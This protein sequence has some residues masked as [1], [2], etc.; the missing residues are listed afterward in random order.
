[1]DNELTSR[2]LALKV[3]RCE[4]ARRCRNGEALPCSRVAN[5]GADISRRRYPAPEPW[6]GH[7]D[8]AR[9]LFI[10]SNPGA[11]NETSPPRP[12]ASTTDL[13]DDALFDIFDN[14][15]EADGGP[16]R[17]VKGEFQEDGSRQPYWA[18]ALE[19]A[20]ELLNEAQAGV[21]YALTEVVHCGSQIEAGVDQAL[22]PCTQLYLGDVLRLSPARLLIAVGTTARNAI[23]ARYRS[24]GAD[25]RSPLRMAG[26][27]DIEGRIRFLVGVWHPSYARYNHDVA[28]SSQVST[29][30]LIRLRAL[31]RGS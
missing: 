21:D 8:R 6:S 15:F 19:T 20:Q 25:V 2:E 27:V 4:V 9:I 23:S 18:W 30:E 7:L 29:Q 16:G 5:W 26:P 17:I 11:G 3:A 14:A 22:G 1:L 28:I 10:S 24:N 31:M 13:S 12:N